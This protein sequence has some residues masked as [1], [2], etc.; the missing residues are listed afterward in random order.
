MLRRAS[1]TTLTFSVD[2]V[3]AYTRYVCVRLTAANLIGDARMP[4]RSIAI[5]FRVFAGRYAERIF[6][7]ELV[8]GATA[9]VPRSAP[10]NRRSDGRAEAS[11]RTATVDIRGL[12]QFGRAFVT[13]DLVGRG[14]LLGGHR[15]QYAPKDRQW[16][17]PKSSYAN[18]GIHWFRVGTLRRRRPS[19]VPRTS[20]CSVCELL[21]RSI[22]CDTV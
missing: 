20:R 16:N 1:H 15:P 14:W 3:R 2:D 22:I 21:R 18:C 19:E 13:R 7:C 5:Q 6:A 17:E 8:H 9:V 12:C 10:D 11:S 4:E